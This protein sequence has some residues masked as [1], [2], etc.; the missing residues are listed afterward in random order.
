MFSRTHGISRRKRLGAPLA[1]VAG[2]LGL[3]RVWVRYDELIDERVRRT[4]T[5]CLVWYH[6]GH[7]G[8]GGGHCGSDK[9][10]ARG[11]E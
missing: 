10:D 2:A 4:P 8:R 6:G 7:R 3:H 11:S 9:R 1:F 5:L